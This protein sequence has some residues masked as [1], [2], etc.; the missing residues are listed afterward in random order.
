MTDARRLYVTKWHE[1][2]GPHPQWRWRLVF[3]HSGWTNQTILTEA[4]FDAK[5][6]MIDIGLSFVALGHAIRAG[7]TA[8]PETS[9][10]N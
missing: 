6:A 2:K 1:I 9:P 8:S 10:E 5:V 4:E 7:T 3:E